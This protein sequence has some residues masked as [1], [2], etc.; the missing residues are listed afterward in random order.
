[1]GLGICIKMNVSVRVGKMQGCF[2]CKIID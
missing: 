1:M 2:L